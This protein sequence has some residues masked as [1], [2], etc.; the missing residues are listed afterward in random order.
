MPLKLTVEAQAAGRNGDAHCVGGVEHGVTTVQKWLRVPH[1][2]RHWWQGVLVAGVVLTAL[3]AHWGVGA[4]LL[5]GLL[6]AS[7]SGF[8]DSR[9]S[10]MLGVLCIACCPLV[11]IARQGAWLS[12]SVLVGYYAANA[13]LYTLIGVPDTLTRWAFYLLGIGLLGQI[14]RYVVRRR[15]QNDG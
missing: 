9:L 7:V 2:H 5:L 12:Q 4:A 15:E 11:I 1:R 13:G 10:L 8:I 14:M 3:L 6:I